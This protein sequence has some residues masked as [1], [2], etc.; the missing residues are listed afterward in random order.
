VSIFRWLNVVRAYDFDQ[1]AARLRTN[2]VERDEQEREHLSRI[3]WQELHRAERSFP[4]GVAL[5][6]E[7]E[8]A[9][10]RPGMS[11][12]LVPPSPAPGHVVPP[13]T[14]TAQVTAA[15]LQDDLAFLL[16][17]GEGEVEEAGRLPRTAITAVDVVDVHDVHVPEPARETIEPP[18]LVFAVLRWTNDGGPDEERFAFQSPWMA[19]QAARRLLDARRG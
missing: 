16:E 1:A 15:V 18:Q 12:S 3:R 2:R 5:V 8:G 17:D 6:P 10:P 4:C 9:P 7:I 19:W 11:P 13:P 14:R